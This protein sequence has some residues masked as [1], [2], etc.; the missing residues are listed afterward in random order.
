MRIV[1]ILCVRNEGAFLLDWLAHHLAC[2]VTH[3]V[4]ASNDCQDGTDAMLD[5]LE[6]LG[7]VTHIRNDAPHDARG[8][9]FTAL[10]RAAETNAMRGADWLLALDIDEFVN[11]HVGDRTLPALIAALPQATAITLTWRLFGN[12]GVVRY[13]DAPVPAQFTRAAPPV[14]L[15]PWRAAMF[16]TLYRNDGT[17]RKP[18]V[19]RP[20]AP[21]RERLS[22]AHWVDGEGRD[23]PPRY[24]E[25]GIFSDYRRPNHRL[26]QLN[27]YPLGAMESYILKADRGRAVHGADRLGMD[28]WVE[29]NWS[30]VEDDSILA[31]APAVAEHR[32]ALAA[33][34]ELARL[35]AVSVDWRHA[36][37][38]TLMRDEAN[39]ALF[40]RLLMTPPARPIPEPLARQLA[41][42]A[43]R[44]MDNP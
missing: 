3:V 14:L 11:V 16:K 9:Q 43:R 8:I 4:A 44:A 10:D 34:P 15:W 22:A 28:Y 39:R 35:H 13:R 38:K 18:G 37:F 31:L 36:R 17:Y 40:A 26:V 19:H 33:D 12:A 2:G 24:R 20:R 30:E 25:K 21:D 23:L 27:H 6:A 7:H 42:Q 1:A 5:R 41:D 32:A 29:R